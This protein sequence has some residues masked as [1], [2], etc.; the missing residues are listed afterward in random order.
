MTVE[1]MK[2]KG[3]FWCELFKL[4]LSHQLLDING[5][6]VIFKDNQAG[7][8]IAIGSGNI[9]NELNILVKDTAIAA[10]QGHGCYV[11]WAKTSSLLQNSIANYLNSK[12]NPLIKPKISKSLPIAVNLPW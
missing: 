9:K 1:W 4:D 2:C 8:I 6:F 12:L 11:T 10:F 5:V 7:N 3:E